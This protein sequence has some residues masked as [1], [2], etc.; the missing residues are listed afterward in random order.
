MDMYWLDE[1]NGNWSDPA[2]WSAEPGGEPGCGVPGP[3]D[4]VKIEG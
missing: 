3:D 4:D 1:S 2:N